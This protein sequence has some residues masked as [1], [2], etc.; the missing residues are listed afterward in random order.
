M[1]R[2]LALLFL[3]SLALAARAQTVRWEG[4][5]ESTDVQLIFED[6]TPDGDPKL[7]PI[8]DSVLTLAGTSSQTTIINGTFSRSTVLTY[9]A[10]ARRAGVT[11]QIPAFTVQT[12]KGPLKVAAFTGGVPRVVPDSTV[13]ARLMTGSTTLWAGEVFS[14]TYTLDAARRSFSQLTSNLD[15]N[16]GALI[17][18]DWSKPEPAE[19]SLNGEPRINITNKTRAYAKTPGPLV[20]NPATQNV[21]IATGSIGFGLFQ[22]QRVEDLTVTTKRPELTI[23]AL[24]TPNVTG[25]SGAVG[26]FKLI[27]KVVPTNAAVGEPITWTLE[28]SGSGNWPDIAG[29]PQ[30][31][32]SKDFQVVQPKAKRTPTEGKLFDVT[33]TEDVVLVPTHPGTYTL[34]PI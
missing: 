16:P 28:L 14:L 7:P 23:R 3:L 6:C 5:E 15:W 18:E 9:N 20:L 2:F 1:R 30:R 11:L 21:R 27:S 26:D 24:P 8:E 32:V 19:L 12:N 13:N 22:Q 34:G 10:R 25:F 33:L 29:L 17:V 4:S 31:D